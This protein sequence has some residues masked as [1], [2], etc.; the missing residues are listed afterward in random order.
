MEALSASRSRLERRSE[1]LHLAAHLQGISAALIRSPHHRLG[2]A[3]DEALAEWGQA[4]EADRVV[5]CT[6]DSGHF[7][8]RQTWEHRPN[9]RARPIPSGAVES[10]LD[11]IH[12]E[13]TLV[14]VNR[15]QFSALR[16]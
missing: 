9:G 6:R 10:L 3:I 13:H 5:V 11:R 7:V 8:P 2:S 15:K 1:A 12:L 14:C 4:L 16:G